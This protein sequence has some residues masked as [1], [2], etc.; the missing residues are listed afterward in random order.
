MLNRSGDSG[1]PCLVPDFR[2]NGFS[3][4]PLSMILAVGLSYTAFTMLRYIPY[5]T[6]FL[7]AFIMM[8]CWILSKAFSVVFVFAFI[9]V[10][11]YI[12]RFA[13]G[14]PPLNPWDEPDLVVVNDLSDV[15]LDSVCHYFIEDFC[16]KEVWFETTQ[17]WGI[18]LWHSKQ[19][20]TVPFH[21]TKS[22]VEI[23]VLV[24]STILVFWGYY[25]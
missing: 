19:S 12:Y 21:F 16:I 15:F 23:S 17:S 4:S 13:Y 7:R 1:H 20:N 3:F 6:S 8:W 9:D 25:K 5:S 14:E 18:L 24:Y 22:Y 10:L 11:Y 2:G